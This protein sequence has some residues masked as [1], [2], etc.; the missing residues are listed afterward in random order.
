[1]TTSVDIANRALAQIGTRSQLTGTVIVPSQSSE[2]LYAS[3][4]Y[5]PLRD[6][7]L[8]EGDYDFSMVQAAT[9]LS[10]GGFSTP[11]LFGY[12]YPS[13]A[14]RI[15]QMLPAS[16]LAL[17]PQPIEW[18]IINAAGTKKIVT[19]VSATNVTYTA[20]PASEDLWDSIFTEAY[21]R[22]LASSL[23]FALENRIEASKEKLQEA[24]SFAGIANLRDS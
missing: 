20:A 24:I 12:T 6:F 14:L 19:T 18:A 4:L 2:A 8:R 1:M 17:D 15:R 13:G 21:T 10:A 11:W 3:L 23:A 9:V 5:A 22:L 7:L 16:Y